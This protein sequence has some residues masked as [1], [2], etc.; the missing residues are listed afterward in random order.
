MPRF[1][2]RRKDTVRRNAVDYANIITELLIPNIPDEAI[3]KS[4]KHAITQFN[5]ANKASLCP[6]V[7]EPIDVNLTALVAHA[8]TFDVPLFEPLY[9]ILLQLAPHLIWENYYSKPERH[10]E[11]K[12]DFAFTEVVGPNGLVH[13]KGFSCGVTYVN[14]NTFYPWH[15]HPATETYLC[16]TGNSEWGL[17]TPPLKPT[18]FGDVIYH[19][20]S[21]AHAMLTTD[22]ALLAPWIWS[23]DVKTKAAMSQPLDDE[24]AQDISDVLE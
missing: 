23:G 5:A 6:N 7:T 17:F 19:P 18:A 1:E 2:D 20:S 4:T 14:K 15:D 9:E 11:S 10:G 3:A 8:R 12:G 24:A 16:L 21:A 13:A 22:Q